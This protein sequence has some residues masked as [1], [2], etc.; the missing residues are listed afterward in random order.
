MTTLWMWEA[1]RWGSANW[2]HRSE[3]KSLHPLCTQHIAGFLHYGAWDS[4][5]NFMFCKSQFALR[6]FQHSFTDI[7][8]AHIEVLC[9]G[10][11]RWKKDQI[12]P[13][14]LNMACYIVNKSQNYSKISIYY[15]NTRTQ[16]GHICKRC[17]ACVK[18][19]IFHFC[20]CISPPINNLQAETLSSSASRR[21]NVHTAN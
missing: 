15:V 21:S 13:M 18:Y 20:L 8:K 10:W 6:S 4:N 5:T 3:S 11:K 7:F 16:T 14:Y 12:C 2:S 19:L 17:K 1:L 9:H